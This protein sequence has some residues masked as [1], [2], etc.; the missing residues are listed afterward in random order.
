MACH[1]TLG[2]VV[3]GIKSYTF[4]QAPWSYQHNIE[5][6]VIPAITLL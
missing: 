1:I 4:Q 3:I 5:Q 2:S 6:D